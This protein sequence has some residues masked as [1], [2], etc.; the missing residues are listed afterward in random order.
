MIYDLFVLK[1]EMNVYIQQKVTQ[2]FWKQGWNIQTS[3]LTAINW[4]HFKTQ[5]WFPR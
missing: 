1:T 5:L 2:W 4:E 3:A